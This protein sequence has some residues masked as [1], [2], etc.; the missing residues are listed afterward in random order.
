METPLDRAHSRRKP[1][2][3]CRLVTAPQC[4]QR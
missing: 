1:N 3:L 4:S 2:R